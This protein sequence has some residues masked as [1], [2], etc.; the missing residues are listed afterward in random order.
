MKRILLFMF[1][2]S[3]ANA[4]IKFAVPPSETS[5]Y[6][7]QTESHPSTMVATSNWNWEW[8]W[9][10]GTA[11]K[12]HRGVLRTVT[13]PLRHPVRAVRRTTKTVLFPVIHPVKTAKGIKRFAW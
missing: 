1:L 11:P 9:S 12:H 13:F 5:A 2:A 10:G 6:I 4:G 8:N 7:V 3:I